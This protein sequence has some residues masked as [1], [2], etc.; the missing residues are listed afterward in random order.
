MAK[1][2]FVLFDYSYSRMVEMPES[3]RMTFPQANWLD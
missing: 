1:S 3:L 2:G